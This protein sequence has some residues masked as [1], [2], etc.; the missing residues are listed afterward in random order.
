M[1]SK[2]KIQTNFRRFEK[3]YLLTRAQYEVLHEAFQRYFVPDEYGQYTIG[4]VYYDTANYELIRASLE[5]PV[6][7]VK[8]RLRSYGVPVDGSS[9]FVELKSKFDG[10]VYKRRAVME[11]G[12]ALAYLSGAAG[13]MQG[14]QIRREIDW[15]LNFYNLA[16]KVLIAYDREALAGCEN[17]DFRV[18]FDTNLRWRNINLDLRDGYAGQQFLPD[19]TVLMEVKIPGAAPV[20]MGRLFSELGIFPASFSKYGTCY[21]KYLLPCFSAARPVELKEVLICA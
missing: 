8:L 14:D 7:K 17:S 6:Y 2:V 1:A 13:D 5:K 11:V 9:V 21:S 15:V 20:W 10:V 16:P 19:D 3:K 4:N 12:E 18:T